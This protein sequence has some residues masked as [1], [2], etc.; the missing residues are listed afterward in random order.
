MSTSIDFNKYEAVIGLEV[1]A[2]LQT[3]SKLFCSDS[4][5]FGG[6]PNTH[7]SPITMGHPG[8]LPKLNGKAVDYAIKLG[9]ACHCT[10]E[11]ENYFARKNYFYPDLPKGYQVSQHTAPICTGGYVTI[12]VEGGE[13]SVQL[14]R[15]HMEEDAGKSLHDQEP[16]YTMVDYNRAGVPLVEIVTEP[17]LHSGDEAYAYLTVLRRLVRYLEV[18]DGNMEEGS[19]RCDAN[20]SVRLKGEQGLGTKVEVK[21]MN[22]IRNVKRAIENEIV[23]QI[24][25]LETGGTIVQETRSFDASNGSSFS[26]RSKEEANDY[27]YFPEPDLAPFRVSE[28]Y[29]TRIRATLP[30]LPEELVARYTKEYGL[31]EYDAHVLTDD[32]AT[33]DYFNLLTGANAAYKA[34]ANWMLGPVK[35][36]LNEHSLSIQ[37]FALPPSALAALIQLVEEGKVS[38]SIASSRIFPELVLNPGKAP[39]DIATSLNLLQD[40][41]A[42]NISPIIDQVLAAYPDKV[43][44]FRSGKKGLMGLFVGEVMKLSKGKADPKL[45]NQLLAEKLKG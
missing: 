39:I 45:T 35:S 18:C 27:R 4:A 14:N 41:N 3:D 31:S 20:I 6:A 43:K 15:I 37:E 25:L 5:A 7:I 10:I 19:M 26:L 12:P 34:A 8:T 17:D 1:H 32:K 29:I 13:R 30:A 28:E 42:D 16:D 22:S 33:S 38:F 36:Y 23:R 9:M 40:N 21:N 2:Q 11:Q 44:E 24:T